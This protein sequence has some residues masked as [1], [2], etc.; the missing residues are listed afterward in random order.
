VAEDK[1]ATDKAEPS[2]SGGGRELV[3]AQ[4]YRLAAA[5]RLPE[6]DLQG[7]EA[8]TVHD[9]R[10]PEDLLFARVLPHGMQPRLT[11]MN[12]LRHM[13]EAKVIQP[14]DWGPVR[15]PGAGDQQL[16]I[17]FR[18]PVNHL[19]MPEWK[20][21]IQPMAADDILRRVLAPAPLTLAFLAH[22]GLTHRALRPDNIYWDGEARSSVLLG[23]CVSGPPGSTQPA[24]FESIESAM[25]PP[26]ARG[27][28]ALQ[29]DFYA[30]GVTLLILSMGHCPVAAMTDEQIND[31]KLQKGS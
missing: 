29:D 20:A 2:R 14:L 12:N 10:A 23:D 3:I 21:E 31:M 30:L 17:V 13:R 15:L 7:V 26:L 28:G 22:R 16:A 18:R 8:Y 4:R 9:D 27:D 19:L 5:S 1:P 6:L 11:V 24:V 25:T